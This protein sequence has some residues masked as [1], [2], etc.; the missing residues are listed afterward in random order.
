M[1]PESQQVMLASAPVL[2]TQGLGATDCYP[3][4]LPHQRDRT[5]C[6]SAPIHTAPVRA[7]RQDP[8]QPL[9][10]PQ[11]STL[12]DGRLGAGPAGLGR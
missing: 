1:G 8:W 7:R 9:S 6:G 5:R 11:R 12:L 4:T 2:Q 3:E 10:S